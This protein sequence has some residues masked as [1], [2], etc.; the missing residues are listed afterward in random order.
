MHSLSPSSSSFAT[1][2]TPTTP[3]ASLSASRPAG[4]SAASAVGSPLTQQHAEALLGTVQELVHLLRSQAA[5]VR[6]SADLLR[7]VAA[8]VEDGAGGGLGRGVDAAARA[9]HK[10]EAAM[11]VLANPA[12]PEEYKAAAGE[13]LKKFFSTD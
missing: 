4:A 2:H 13:Y 11:E 1:A 7:R 9:R 8:A 12:V 10:S 6:A 3:S 5:D